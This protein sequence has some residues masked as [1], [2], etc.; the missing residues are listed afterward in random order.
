M[1]NEV[2]LL[3]S[4]LG[5]IALQLSFVARALLRPH[6]EASSRVAWVL[7]I[8]TMPT[9]GMIAYVLFGETSIGRKRLERYHLIARRIRQEAAKDLMEGQF[10]EVDGKYRHLF[11]LGQSVNGLG[12]LGGNRGQLM[13]NTNEAFRCLVADIDAAQES[14]HLLFYI[15]LDDTNGLKVADAAQRA[16]R[17]G[18]TV[19]V[20]ADD[21]GSRK[22]IRSK[23]WQAMQEAGVKTERALPVGRLILH[24]IRGRVD[25]RNHRKIAVVDNAIAYCGSPNCADPEFR[26]KPR[27]APW[28]D[29]M[30]RFEG[31]VAIQTQYLFVEDWMAHTDEDILDYVR[32]VSLPNQDGGIV[33]Q[34]IGTGPTIRNSAMPE[35]FEV[36]IHAAR[37]KL[38]I[39]T[40][41]YVPSDAMHD[42]LCLTARRGVR[43]VLMLP[44]NN[45]SWIVAAASRSY[46]RDLIEAGVQIYEYPDGLLH[47]K[48]LTLDG[49]VA[50]IGSAN[51]DRRSFELNYENNVLLQDRELTS[52]LETRQESYIGASRQIEAEEIAEWG[53][54]R[55]LWNNTVGMMGPVL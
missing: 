48:I 10:N 1:T 15:W 54:G 32:K 8:L 2:I 40:P 38:L 37:H 53:R 4:V 25:L 35:V 20:M 13:E 34:A 26:I 5:H 45:D 30:V 22:F 9:I 21:I 51:L 31:P 47:A 11:S 16:A 50:L 24:P 49:E 7:V 27:F 33:T 14:V 23:H 41:Y 42:A 28:V 3:T 18:V 6:R 36:L 52:S 12:P 39:T 46:Y 19:R 44:E 29:Q 43:T 17:R 55:R